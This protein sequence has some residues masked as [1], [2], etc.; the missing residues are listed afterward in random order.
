MSGGESRST[1][2]LIHQVVAIARSVL[3]LATHVEPGRYLPA[4]PLVIPQCLGQPSRLVTGQCVHRIQKDRLDAWPLANAP[5]VVED[6][7]E[8][9]LGLA[10]PRPR[11]YQ[12]V[13]RLVSVL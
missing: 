4:Q 11:G 10:R 3:A 2:R 8:E 1:S 13:L 6:R 7:E 12:R 5:A 9:A